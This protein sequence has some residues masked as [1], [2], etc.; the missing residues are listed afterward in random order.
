MVG[1][2][3]VQNGEKWLDFSKYTA[4]REFLILLVS[5]SVHSGPASSLT[6]SIRNEKI[7]IGSA[8]SAN[9]KVSDICTVFAKYFALNLARQFSPVA[10][11]VAGSRG[12]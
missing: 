7:Q 2:N 8:I 5:R 6:V 1:F 12:H 4:T 10:M 9:F 11:W 3:S